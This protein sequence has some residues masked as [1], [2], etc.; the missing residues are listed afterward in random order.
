[1]LVSEQVG[2]LFFDSGSGSERLEYTEYGAGPHWFVLLHGRL[3]PRRMHQ[4]LARPWRER[5]CTW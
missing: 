5:G 1:M 4:P 2:Q 3:M